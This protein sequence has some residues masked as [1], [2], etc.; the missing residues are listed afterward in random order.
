MSIRINIHVPTNPSF[1]NLAVLLSRPK[2]SC[3]ALCVYCR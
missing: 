2:A 3:A 1:Y